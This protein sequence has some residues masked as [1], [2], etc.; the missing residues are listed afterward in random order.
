MIITFGSLNADF[1]YDMASLPQPGQTLQATKLRI[2]GGGKGANQAVAAAR[3]GASVMM[4][5]SVG[6]DHLAPLVLEN[7]VHAKVD[8]KCVTT[9]NTTTGSA[10]IYVD[11]HGQNQIVVASGANGHA[12]SE[13]ISDEL[14]NSAS[15][16]L[17]QMENDISEIELLLYRAKK[18]RVLSIL[19][20]APALHIDHEALC[21][22]DIL[23]VN[24]DEAE[25]AG[26]WFD[27]D[28]T[29][30]ALSKSLNT[31]VVRTMG[32]QGAEIAGRMGNH[33]LPANTISA[34]DTTAAGDCFIGV[35]ASALDAESNIKQAIIRAS[36]AAA[37][38][39]TREGSQSSLPWKNE[40]TEYLAN[41]N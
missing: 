30:I 35:M 38:C 28:A 36:A 25:T 16:L 32:A 11:E 20:L 37:I 9:A 3:D 39:C 40:T 18:Y 15:M 17:L 5:G 1:I 14:L 27:C 8:A 6:N 34:V 4:V 19:N 2:E 33:F 7:L 29:A 12:K 23:V 31:N 41:A 24:E 10:S 22:C 26:G 13:Q 21:L